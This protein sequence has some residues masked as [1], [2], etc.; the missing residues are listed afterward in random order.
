M[1]SS[2]IFT[3]EE[4]RVLK[5]CLKHRDP[6]DVKFRKNAKLE[7]KSMNNILDSAKRKIKD[8]HLDQ[9]GYRCCYCAVD[10]R[11]RDIETDREHI[12]PKGKFKE[13]SYTIFNISVACKRC[14]MK[15][16]GEDTSHILNINKIKSNLYK[17]DSYLMPHPNLCKYENH[18]TRFHLDIPSGAITI[19]K[20]VNGSK[21]GNF[22]YNYFELKELE[23]RSISKAQGIIAKALVDFG[24]FSEALELPD[25]SGPV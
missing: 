1:L 19:Y 24:V 9:T 6:W 21:K 10:F 13:L 16:K 20:V 15:I 23:Q 17:I 4:V 2:N 12:V 11:D 14:N 25:I 3:S 5:I 22:L 8:F 7:G 18:L